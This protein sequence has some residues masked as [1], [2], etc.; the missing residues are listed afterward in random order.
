MQDTITG[1]LTNDTKGMVST[2]F[3][4]QMKKGTYLINTARG[5]LIDEN[6]LFD[7]I[8]NGTLRGAALDVFARATGLQQSCAGSAP[9]DRRTA[10]EFTY[11]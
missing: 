9:G 7:A 6:A 1:P 10:Y 5:E 8:Q 2:N 3:M 11:R 4:T